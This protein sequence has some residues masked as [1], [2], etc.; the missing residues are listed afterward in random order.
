MKRLDENENGK[1][2]T[3]EI[4]RLNQHFKQ[5][6]GASR[7]RASVT[8]PAPAQPPAGTKSAEEKKSE[9]KKTEEKKPEEKKSELPKKEN[10]KFDA[11]K[12]PFLPGTASKP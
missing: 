12:D 2:E 5:M 11:S 10:D 1:L 8:P 4:E 3:N 6:G 9:D 7:E